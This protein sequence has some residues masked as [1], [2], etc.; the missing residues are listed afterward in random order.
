MRRGRGVDRECETG[1]GSVRVR[2]ETEMGSGQ[3]VRDGDG[4][5]TGNERRGRGVDRECETGTGSGQGV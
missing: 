4:E 3:E 1:T 2:R 5:W